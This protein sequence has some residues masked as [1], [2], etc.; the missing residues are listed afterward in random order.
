MHDP[1]G[2]RDD[3]PHRAEK[4]ADEDALAA[5]SGEKPD[6]ARQQSGLRVNGQT[7]AI[8]PPKRRPIQYDTVSP[9]TAPR[10]APARIGKY[11]SEPAAIRAPAAINSEVPGNSRLKKA[12]NSPNAVT[13]M[14]ATAQ[15]ECAEMKARVG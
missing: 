8:P 9:S 3:R 4:A 2:E 1:G 10:I 13:N 14:T 7:R 12:N 6:A 11:G 5:V 15:P